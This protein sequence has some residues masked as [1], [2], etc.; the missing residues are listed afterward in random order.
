MRVYN[1]KA[2][3][4]NGCEMTVKVLGDT[5]KI[6]SITITFG[7]AKAGAFTVNGVAG[8]YDTATYTIDSNTFTIKNVD[9]S[10]STANMDI[11]SIVIEYSLA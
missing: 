3:T 9:T 4:G 11:K 5:A 8:S 1:E 2:A 10:T 6:K 7:S